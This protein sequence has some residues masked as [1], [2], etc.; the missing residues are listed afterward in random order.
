MKKRVLDAFGSAVAIAIVMPAMAQDQSASDF[1]TPEYLRN[2]GLQYTFAAD[3]Y[4]LGFTGEGVKIG[5]ADSA[6]QLSHPEFAGRV[7]W[8]DPEPPA[9]TASAPH[10]CQVGF[11]G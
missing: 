6:V 5:I 9:Y 2:W 4:A 10:A 7:F 1:I 8:P 11:P 3:A